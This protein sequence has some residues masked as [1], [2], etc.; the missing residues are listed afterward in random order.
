MYYVNVQDIRLR[1]G[2]M[3]ELE[4]AL[5]EL[6]AGWQGTLLQGLAQERALHLAIETVTDVG[7]CLI[8]G[9]IMR[10]ASSYEDIVE[11]IGGEEVIDAGLARSLAELAS[12][13][14]KLVQEYYDW[15][16]SELHPF[17]AQLPGWLASFREQVEIYL[18]KEQ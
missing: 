7:S 18:A 2:A 3:P 17:T 12:L 11:I 15:P 10:D 16:R 1:L 6:A 5:R 14:R 4:Q 8:D 9:Y 13:R